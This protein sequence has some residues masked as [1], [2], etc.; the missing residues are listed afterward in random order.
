MVLDGTRYASLALKTTCFGGLGTGCLLSMAMGRIQASFG[1]SKPDNLYSLGYE[2]SFLF[3]RTIGAIHSEYGLAPSE[4]WPLLP[5]QVVEHMGL[6]LGGTYTQSLLPVF[7][8]CSIR[9]ILAKGSSLRLNATELIRN[10]RIM[11][12]TALR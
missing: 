9:L 12:F 4:A 1:C 6:N 8:L 2:L 10:S 5:Q 7:I 11:A 3:T